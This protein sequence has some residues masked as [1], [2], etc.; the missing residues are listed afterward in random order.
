MDFAF[1]FFFLNNL[2]V[3]NNLGVAQFVSLIFS[4]KQCLH[5]HFV[6]LFDVI[7]FNFISSNFNSEA[8]LVAKSALA[9][10][11]MNATHGD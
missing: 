10:F 11:V 2:L 6:P 4:M 5:Y 1:L 9:V 3:T 7:S 8:D